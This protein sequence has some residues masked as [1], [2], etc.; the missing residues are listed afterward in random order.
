MLSVL[1]LTVFVS[2]C[3][4]PGTDIQLPCFPPFCGTQVIEERADIVTI[5]S[6]NIF[7]S[8]AAPGQQVRLVAYIQNMDKHDKIPQPGLGSNEKISV[9]LYDYCEGMFN[10]IEVSCDGTQNNHKKKCEG[11]ELL[12]QEI[13]EIDWTM[14]VADLPLKTQCELK[15]RVHYP[16]KTTS[17]TTVYFINHDEMQRQ[18][19]EGTFRQ[20]DSLISK[21]PGPI[22]A[23][24]TLLDQQPIPIKDKEG[25]S[26]LSL[27]IENRGD[28]FPKK[29][30]DGGKKYDILK[31]K[32]TLKLPEQFKLQTNGNCGF[33]NNKP[34]ESIN[35][36]KG[37]SSKIVCPVNFKNMNVPLESS[38]HM[39]VDVE[40]GY[41]FRKSV[42]FR[43]EPKI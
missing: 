41:E 5:K 13:K 38:M 15:V 11:I 12:P 6:L 28:G 16:Y 29:T 37:K 9:E 22:K 3:T 2:G 35:L 27:E 33:Q 20:R 26:A 40:Y 1:V 43:V 19:E 42:L 39:T 18:L 32:V 30:N 7:P 25:T 21:G 10:N 23:Y 24:L 36:I 34:K 17:M 31:D 4:M 14:T 8:K